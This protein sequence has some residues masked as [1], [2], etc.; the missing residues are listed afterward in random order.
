MALALVIALRMTV[1]RAGEDWE[2]AAALTSAQADVIVVAEET[3]WGLVP[4]SV[5]GRVFRDTLGRLTQRLAASA[6]RVELVVAGFAVDLR[7]IGMPIG[8]VRR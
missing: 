5:L 6:D 4:P 8:D 1:P 7:G 2:L 3:G